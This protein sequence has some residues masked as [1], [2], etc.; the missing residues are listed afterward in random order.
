MLY[1]VYAEAG[2]VSETWQGQKLG[3]PIRSLTLITNGIQYNM[4]LPV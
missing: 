2:E 1:N 4:H 3:H